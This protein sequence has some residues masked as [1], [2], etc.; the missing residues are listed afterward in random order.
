V[1]GQPSHAVSVVDIAQLK[2]LV[3]AE[4]NDRRHDIG[5]VSL[6]AL[7]FADA[8]WRAVIKPSGEWPEG[9]AI[10]LSEI[11]E[12]VFD[13]SGVNIMLVPVQP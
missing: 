6:D 11:E 1:S 5:P 10:A 8:A 13:Q 12:T 3:V 7:E 2:Q 9:Y 4:L